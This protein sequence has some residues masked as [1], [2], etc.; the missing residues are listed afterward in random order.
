MQAI[1]RKKSL[2]R[3]PPYN[4]DMSR[5]RKPTQEAPLF[6][7]RLVHFRQKT[8]MTQ[9]ELAEALGISRDLVGHYERRSQNP[10]LEFV[11]K[12]AKLFEVSVDEFLGFKTTPEKSGPP[13]RVK[14]L[15]RRLVDLPKTKQGVVL[16]MLE[17]YL[18]KAS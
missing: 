18:D 16:E 7:Q 10:N 11:I 2:S 13:P 6:G 14:K 12:V 5:G 9:Y 4:G 3:F 8:G 1:S 17:S 15:T